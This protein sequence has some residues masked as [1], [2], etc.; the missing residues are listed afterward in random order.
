MSNRYKKHSP[1]AKPVTAKLTQSAAPTV[2]KPVPV[3]PSTQFHWRDHPIVIAALA[4]VGTF[5]VTSYTFKEIII[6]TQIAGMPALMQKV[7]EFEDTNAKQAEQINF[8]RKSLE[9]I[10]H[11]S[12][13]TAKD[14]FPASLG[15]VRLDQSIELLEAAFP[16]TNIKKNDEFWSVDFGF[17]VVS[18][19]VYYFDEKS[20]K[21]THVMFW[22][23]EDG[24]RSRS[25][26]HDRLVDSLGAPTQNPKKTFFEWNTGRY[27]VF[28]TDDSRFII[29]NRDNRPG[30]WP[31]S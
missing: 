11:Q 29:H 9:S 7:T 20:Q 17:G 10:Q 26:L 27:N 14:P 8:L 1:A 15:A 25:F 5:T 2:G 23:S 22:L 21:V 28:T 4:A 19:G 3:T 30:Y 31:K 18:R 6:P 16:S 13:F 24:E 12:L